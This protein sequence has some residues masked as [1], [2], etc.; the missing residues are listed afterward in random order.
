[1]PARSYSHSRRWSPMGAH[2]IRTVITRSLFEG[3]VGATENLIDSLDFKKVKSLV[4]HQVQRTWVI[5]NLYCLPTGH[6]QMQPLSLSVQPRGNL[7]MCIRHMKKLFR[8]AKDC[9][10]EI[11]EI[12]CERVTQWDATWQWKQT[13]PEAAE[14]KPNKMF[15]KHIYLYK[16]KKQTPHKHAFF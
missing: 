8:V 11:G 12:N 3:P 5:S 6:N 13:T 2:L 1:M 10:Q 7:D 14:A 15:F 4:Q 9:W 16:K